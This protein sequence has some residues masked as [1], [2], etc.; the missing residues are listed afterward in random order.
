MA[1]L[2]QFS[3]LEQSKFW[4]KSPNEYVNML[5]ETNDILKH[6]PFVKGNESDGHSGVQIIGES[7]AY[8]KAHN[9]G[10]IPS[11][12]TTTVNKIECKMLESRLSISTDLCES[13]EAKGT[14]LEIQ[15]EEKI[16][17]LGKK[18]AQAIIYGSAGTGTRQPKGLAQYYNK[19]SSSSTDPIAENVIDG[20]G[21][22]SDNTSV[23][24]VAPSDRTF[25]MIYPSGSKSG[26]LQIDDIQ[27]YVK[28]DSNGAELDCYKQV[29]KWHLG[30][31]IANWKNA[32]V[33]VCNLDASNLN[34]GTGAANLANLMIKAVHKM[35][36]TPRVGYWLMNG[37]TLS[38]LDTQI[39]DS[40]NNASLSYKDYDGKEVMHFRGYPILRCDAIINNEARIV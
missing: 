16:T 3:L 17:T 27:K 19:V 23:W 7:E 11:T 4:G 6:L 37:D 5:V 9:E 2:N 32:A 25:H 13:G 8:W 30:L 40:V 31:F 12:A 29:Y 24:F 22:G 34:S 36:E 38:A 28:V 33:R 14:N 20:G 15:R 39:Y 26:G 21:T 10:V 35:H 18:V 1:I